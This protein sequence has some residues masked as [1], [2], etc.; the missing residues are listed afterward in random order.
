MFTWLNDGPSYLSLFDPKPQTRDQYRDP[1]G[2]IATHLPS[3]RF[4]K[5]A[6]RNDILSLVRSNVT[7]S[8]G[9]RQV[10]SIT[11]TGYQASDGG[12]P[13]GTPRDY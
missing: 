8:S 5:L 2:T 9:Y 4:A 1:F 7:H 13:D 11:L 10:G 3:I 6:T 12:E